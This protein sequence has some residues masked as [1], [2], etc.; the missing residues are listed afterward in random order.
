MVIKDNGVKLVDPRGEMLEQ[1]WESYATKLANVND[2]EALGQ[3]ITDI[4]TA[5]DINLE[6]PAAVIYA[7][8]TR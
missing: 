8:D 4:A 3:V 5:Q 7:H 1:S 2:G 6:S